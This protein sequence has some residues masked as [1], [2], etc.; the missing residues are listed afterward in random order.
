MSLYGFKIIISERISVPQNI[1]CSVILPDFLETIL[2]NYVLKSV[3]FVSTLIGV[4]LYLL[5]SFDP[6]C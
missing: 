6:F 2:G 5:I 1:A 4:D 3:K